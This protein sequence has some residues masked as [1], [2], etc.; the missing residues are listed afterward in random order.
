MKRR[1]TT[2]SCAPNLDLEEC[3]AYAEHPEGDNIIHSRHLCHRG[4]RAQTLDRM[5]LLISEMENEKRQ[6]DGVRI[7]NVQIPCNAFSSMT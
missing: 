6:K 2:Y 7:F 5:F 3:L 4:R 1:L